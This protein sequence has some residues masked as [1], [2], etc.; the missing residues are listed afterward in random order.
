M[1]QL[2]VIGES[3]PFIARL[4]HRFAEECGLQAVHAQVGQELFELVR[5]AKPAVVILEVELPGKMRGWEAARALKADPETRR[6]PIISCSWLAEADARA[7]A[8]GMC[9]HLQKPE[10][11][12]DDFSA[13]L[14]KAG[15]EAGPPLA[16]QE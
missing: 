12:C 8:G 3:D 7:L 11:H 4:L 10:L 6:I 14:K 1:P 9:A 16:P 2:C 5:Q 13:A 15:V